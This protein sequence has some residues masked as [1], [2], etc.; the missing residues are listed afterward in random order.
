VTEHNSF[1]VA[2]QIFAHKAGLPRESLLFES[3]HASGDEKVKYDPTKKYS[4]LAEF[5]FDSSVS[6]HIFVSEYNSL[7]L[8]QIKRMTVIYR[9]NAPAESDKKQ[10]IVLFMKGAVERVLSVCS[11]CIDADSTV[12]SLDKERSNAI[13]E[14]M[15]A[16]ATKG[17]R[18][19][20]FGMRRESA[21]FGYAK[22]EKPLDLKREDAERD[23][24]FIGLVGIYDPPRLES[25][26]AVRACKKAS[27]RVRM[28]TGD[29]PATAVSCSLF[30]YGICTHTFVGCYCS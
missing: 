30:L 26:P 13:I 7:M 5:N 3:V 24:C 15:D 11:T 1:Q 29:H 22:G 12:V 27:I 10:P 2:L 6:Y 14:E 16:L 4:S 25:L 19:L 28:L 21:D 9:D 20:A 23:M 8:D 18:V 17:L